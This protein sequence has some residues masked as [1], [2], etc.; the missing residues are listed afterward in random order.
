MVQ[1]GFSINTEVK[2]EDQTVTQILIMF[3][4]IWTC[5]W[6]F[7]MATGKMCF[8][9]AYSF[10]KVIIINQKLSYPPHHNV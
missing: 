7:R 6:L 8:K 9:T 4:H 2:I 1:R 10:L 5:F 3:G